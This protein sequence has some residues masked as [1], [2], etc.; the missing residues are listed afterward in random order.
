V[1]ELPGETRAKYL[2]EIVENSRLGLL[3]RDAGCQVKVQISLRFV[4]SRRL[5]IT[6]LT[7]EV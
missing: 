4:L 5:S 7:A 2:Q 1:G 6:V 3:D